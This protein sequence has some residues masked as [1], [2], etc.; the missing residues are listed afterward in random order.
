MSVEQRVAALDISLFERIVSQTTA[1]D[2]RSLLAVHRAL[3][4]RL[5]RFAYL[6]IGSH[7]GGT[8]QALIADRRCVRIVS[9]DARPPRQPDDRGAVYEYPGNSTSR[10]LSML[11]EVPGADLGKLYTIDAGTDELSPESLRRPD[12]AFVDGEHTRAAALRDAR[13]CRAA[14]EGAGVVVFHDRG[15][16]ADAIE[17]FVRETRGP[18]RA[19]PLHTSLFVVELGAA[20]SLLGD[21]AVRRQ[22]PRAGVWTLANRVRGG[23]VALGAALRWRTLRRRGSRHR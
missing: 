21:P 2:R 8:L 14:M 1:E 18:L 13:F 10:M 16:V 19:F 17:D 6:E 3:G 4:L 5:G 11:A 9:I 22:V 20:P 12:L 7:L 23:R 15:V